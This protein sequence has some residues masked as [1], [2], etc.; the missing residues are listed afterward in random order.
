[1]SAPPHR[2]LR[3]LAHGAGR[4]AALGPRGWLLLV[5]AQASLLWATLL[6]RRHP[7]G[8]LIAAFASRYSD[9]DPGND[10]LTAAR[11]I[12]VA[13]DRAARFG[14]IRARCLVRSIAL[15]RLLERRGIHGSRIQVGV[16]MRDGAFEAH[17]W[18]H[19]QGVIVGDDPAYVGGFSPLDGLTD[20]MPPL[21]AHRAVVCR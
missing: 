11:E 19:F 14:V 7:Q 15:H 16:R 4:L 6:V 8:D 2:R 3:Q 12:A 13:L 1:M 18:V 17:A 5:D 9:P 21:S 10:D 20:R